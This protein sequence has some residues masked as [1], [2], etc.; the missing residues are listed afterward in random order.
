MYGI[1]TE[2]HN[3]Q[4]STESLPVYSLIKS[5]MRGRLIDGQPHFIEPGHFQ[6]LHSDIPLDV[7]VGEI[8]DNLLQDYVIEITGFVPGKIVPINDDFLIRRRLTALHVQNGQITVI[9]EQVIV[10]VALE[11][12]G[13]SSRIRL[14]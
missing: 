3:F 4:F 1:I 2:N 13:G 7:V 10:D 5:I 12:R 11:R 14:D 8:R 6:V 9:N